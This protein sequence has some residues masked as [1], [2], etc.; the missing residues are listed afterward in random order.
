MKA[1]MSSETVTPS[2]VSVLTL[3]FSYESGAYHCPCVMIDGRVSRPLLLWLISEAKLGASPSTLERYGHAL[4][5]FV[6]YYLASGLSMGPEQLVR[7]YSNALDQGHDLLRWRPLAPKTANGHFDA[8]CRF[9]DWLVRQKGFEHAIHPNPLVKRT[10]DESERHSHRARSAESDMLHHLYP[11]TKSGRGIREYRKYSGRNRWGVRGD[12]PGQVAQ[13][14]CG[15]APSGMS[16]EDYIKLVRTETNPRNRLLWLVLGAGGIR[17][18]EALQLFASDITLDATTHEA[19]VALANPV[20]GKV[21]SPGGKTIERREFL[22]KNYG[23]VPRCMLP[24]NNPL[25]VG[26]KGMLEGGFDDQQRPH[27]ADWRNYRWSLLEWM[28]PMFGRMAW[29]AHVEYMRIRT[30]V[31]PDHPY[32]FVNV[33]KNTG[34][35]M[36]RTNAKQLLATACRRTGIKLHSPHKLRHMYGNYLAGIGMPMAEVQIM[37]HHRSAASTATY[38]RVKRDVARERLAR[39]EK[40][41]ILSK[42]ERNSPYLFSILG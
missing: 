11:L 34:E 19:L 10:M 27:L 40:Q 36:S 26:W 16:V 29:T 5:R 25:H 6:E 12:L 33:E 30:E 39:A 1:L 18:S 7:T 37:M 9:F 31:R 8:F 38:Y 3:P 23:L 35:P 13:V 2:S 20:K 4:R 17:I 21:V 32:Y 14:S 15:W 41:T 24:R 22:S 28:M 42:H